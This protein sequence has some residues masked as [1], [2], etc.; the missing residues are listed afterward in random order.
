MVDKHILI[1][2][3]T[4]LLSIDYYILTGFFFKYAYINYTNFNI[5]YYLNL[6][7]KENT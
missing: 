5:K 4:F 2:C 1:I 7:L 3:Y 6:N